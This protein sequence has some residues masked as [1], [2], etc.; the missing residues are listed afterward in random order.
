MSE[1]RSKVGMAWDFLEL[2]ANAFVSGLV[3]AIV[4]SVLALAL[5]TTAQA[6]DPTP[7]CFKASPD[8][9]A[10]PDE[11]KAAEAYDRDGPPTAYRYAVEL[12]GVANVPVAPT[13]LAVRDTEPWSEAPASPRRQAEDTGALW[14]MFLGLLALSTAGIVAVIGQTVPARRSAPDA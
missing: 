3:A 6:A 13:A 2:G 1:K 8:G 11:P 14:A 7:A 12:C 9:E 5:A 4:L 10:I